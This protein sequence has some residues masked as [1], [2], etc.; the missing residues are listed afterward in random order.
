[1]DL[2]RLNQFVNK[3][4]F[5]K[6]KMSQKK[7][8]TWNLKRKKRRR[9]KK[10]Q[11]KS[12]SSNGITLTN[13]QEAAVWT[14]QTPRVSS[15]EQNCLPHLTKCWAG[16]RTKWKWNVILGSPTNETLFPPSTNITKTPFM[17]IWKFWSYFKNLWGRQKF[18]IEYFVSGKVVR[19]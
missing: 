15:N 11:Y 17:I 13:Y 9:K 4:I 14:T 5:R 6:N 7:K 16:M 18:I 12:I 19:A 8:S 3:V 2:S 1:M 10:T